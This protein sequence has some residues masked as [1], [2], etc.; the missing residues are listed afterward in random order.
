MRYK[1][2]RYRDMAHTGA[3]DRL[4]QQLEEDA[5]QPDDARANLVGD[6]DFYNAQHF[7]DHEDIT[8]WTNWP[9]ALIDQTM[10]WCLFPD[11]VGP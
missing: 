10:Q 11:W 6:I 8:Y 5:L 9:G 3:T 2:H 4:D 1:Y 7:L